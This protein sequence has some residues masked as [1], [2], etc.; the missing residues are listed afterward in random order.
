MK[1]FLAI[2]CFLT[3]FSCSNNVKEQSVVV[4]LKGYSVNYD[5]VAVSS[6][7][8]IFSSDKRE[9]IIVPKEL[10]KEV[11]E[12]LKQENKIVS[13]TFQTERTLFGKT[14]TLKS[15]YTLDPE[16]IAHEISFQQSKHKC[17]SQAFTE[18]DMEKCKSF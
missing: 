10:E 15:I 1:N 4:T 17:M 7:V 8:G 6:G 11:E 5:T 12:Y 13:I 3:L 14:H 9:D 16:V 2:V 18:L